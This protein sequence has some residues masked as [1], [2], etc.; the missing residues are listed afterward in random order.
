MKK[1]VL[2]SLTLILTLGI[3]LATAAPA[4]ACMPGKSPG[5]WKNHES[6]WPACHL[7][8]DTLVSFFG[9]EP[10]GISNVTLMEALQTGK[11]SVLFKRPDA[12]FW[13]QL[14]ATLLNQG[15]DDDEEA[16]LIGLVQDI[17]PDGG[18][19]MSSVSPWNVSPFGASWWTLED[20]KD[21]FEAKNNQ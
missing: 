9:V 18:S 6:A 3:V 8:D 4:L 2:V 19:H 13:R 5:Y 21:W 15:C 17:Y 14:V 10:T 16:F 12:Q 20:W 1:I 11:N 7:P